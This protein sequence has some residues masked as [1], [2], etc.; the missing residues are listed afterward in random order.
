MP[1]SVAALTRN[2]A[3]TSSFLRSMNLLFRRVSRSAPTLS[4]TPS[5]SGL[6]EALSTTNSSGSTS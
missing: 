3:C 2:I 4:T 6:S 1:S 5:G